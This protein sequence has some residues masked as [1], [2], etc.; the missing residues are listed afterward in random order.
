MGGGRGRR[1]VGGVVDLYKFVLWFM[2][3]IYLYYLTCI[4]LSRVYVRFYCLSLFV[5]C[6]ELDGILH[7]K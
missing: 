5:Q 1:G 7:Y 6:T 3:V 4:F 2:S